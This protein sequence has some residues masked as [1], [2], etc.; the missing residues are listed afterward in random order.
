M[1]PATTASL[2]PSGRLSARPRATWTWWEGVG[3][4]ILAF[5]VGGLATLP[6]LSTLEGDVD[7]A[8]ITASVIATIVIVAV[9]LAWLSRSHPTWRE[10]L[11][12]PERGR[13]RREVVASV[14]FGLLL[15][16]T[17]V[18]G[19]GIVVSLILAAISGE[20]VRA[21]EQVPS[22][23]S[24]VGVALTTVYALV[25]APVHEELFFRGVLFRGVRDRHGLLRGLAAT[26][27]GFALIHYVDGPWQDALLLMG[28]MLFNGMA[29]GWW[30]ERR[31]TIVAP[32]VAHVTFNVIGLTLILTIQ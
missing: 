13:W 32:I 4:Y 7:L 1:H 5:I 10:I 11:G 30:Y 18:F 12:R 6:I 27:A 17:M 14:G 23:L 20:T 16:P 24:A 8:N 31:G 28:V 25:I 26:G 3:V 29:L 9:L 15:Y 19:V 21:P 2:A 22:E